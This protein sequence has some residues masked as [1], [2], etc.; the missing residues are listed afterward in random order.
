[1]QKEQSKQS[2][3][4]SKVSSVVA[5]S[6][7]VEV[8][9]SPYRMGNWTVTMLKDE[10][11]VR[12]L[13]VSGKKSELI[14]RLEGS[15]IKRAS[16]TADVSIA[17]PKVVFNNSPK[18]ST[19]SSVASKTTAS[20]SKSSPL[21]TN[22]S[23]SN[24]SN[25]LAKVDSQLSPLVEALQN[26][27]LQ[28]KTSVQSPLVQSS[29]TPTPTK[30]GRSDSPSGRR[31]MLTRSRSVSLTRGNYLTWRRTPL[32]IIGNFFMS[33]V[34]GFKGRN[35]IIG[36]VLLLSMAA[37]YF[38]P[39]DVSFKQLIVDQVNSYLPFV[40]DGFLYNLGFDENEF[41]LY[42]SR[43][44]AF[45]FSCEAGNVEKQASTGRLRC[46]AAP[47]EG[48][49]GLEGR[50]FGLY[51]AELLCWTV[52]SAVA[53]WIY[54]ALSRPS[55]SNNLFNSNKKFRSFMSFFNKFYFIFPLLPVEITGILA[56]LSNFSTSKF[57]FTLILKSLVG[58]PLQVLSKV[59]FAKYSNHLTRV[60]SFLSAIKPNI[61]FWQF[62][63]AFSI[64]AL[65]LAAIQ[66]IANTRLLKQYKRN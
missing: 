31:G 63:S 54:F 4:K 60:D 62:I 64:I 22:N 39:M 18:A 15:P 3:R 32:S 28:R 29:P 21:K 26:R 16:A 17:S 14:D 53:C 65:S 51:R 27:L 35:S 37:F 2:P 19:P 7:S 40:L 23:P 34:E 5:D 49:F 8:T 24:T 20:P 25:L 6:S 59:L 10:L 1:M 12:Q 66:N 57:A 33:V 55:A 42:L 44:S 45:M 46:S 38:Y 48:F 13:P 36:L 56:G 41:G 61:L 43:A 52:G 9:G 30:R 47:L 58:T 11:R 50:I